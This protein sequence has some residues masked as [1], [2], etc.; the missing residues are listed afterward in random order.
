[1]K[2][3]NRL[4]VILLFWAVIYCVTRIV[5]DV[6]KRQFLYA[7]PLS[8]YEI[9]MV[10]LVGLFCVLLLLA[11]L[12]AF[13]MKSEWKAEPGGIRLIVIPAALYGAVASF[14][15]ALVP[16][17]TVS[18]SAPDIL[19]YSGIAIAWLSLPF[20]LWHVVYG[21]DLLPQK[22]GG[23]P[24]GIRKIYPSAIALFTV[25][26]YLLCALALE[27][28]RESSALLVG[29]LDALCIVILFMAASA[30]A[31]WP[32]LAI[33]QSKSSAGI[34]GGRKRE[35]GLGVMMIEIGVVLL[36]SSLL[37]LLWYKFDSTGLEVLVIIAM[38]VE[39][40]I[41]VSGCEIAI[42][43][44]GARD[45]IGVSLMGILCGP[46]GLLVV[47]LSVYVLRTQGLEANPCTLA[48]AAYLLAIAIGFLV[49]LAH[50][51]VLFLPNKKPAKAPSQLTFCPLYGQF[52]DSGKTCSTCAY[53][54]DT[55]YLKQRTVTVP[56]PEA[57]GQYQKCQANAPHAGK[58]A[59][60]KK[61]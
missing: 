43:K 17:F 61:G 51:V 14:A 21:L 53:T 20:S 60:G 42:S 23:A 11:M 30:M 27:C 45:K 59:A 34:N 18:Y 4:L 5:V 40:L 39:I 12:R 56:T 6:E 2:K 41:I 15:A 58:T 32:F 29:M 36:C 57:L 1:M 7:A 31:L 26:A 22:K 25:A 9:M 19:R 54:P 3:K 33:A 8:L 46:I 28:S 49:S 16:R 52:I 44:N 48:L 37:Q 55:N 35:T 38:I 13:K 47:G 24:S 50:V 10:F